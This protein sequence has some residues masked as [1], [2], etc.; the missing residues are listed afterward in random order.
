MKIVQ[1]M[2][3]MQNMQNMHKLAPRQSSFGLSGRFLGCMERMLALKK[4][5]VAPPGSILNFCGNF[6]SG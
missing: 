3:K 1:N 4:A 2:Q 5:T 6:Q